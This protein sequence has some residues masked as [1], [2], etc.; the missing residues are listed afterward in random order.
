MSGPS[1]YPGGFA[2]GVVIKGIPLTVS[3]PGKVFWV[4]GTTVLA[5]GAVGGSNGNDG[6]YRRPFAT[7]DYA[8][9]KCTANRGDIIMVMPGHSETISSATSLVFDVAG[10][11]VIGLGTGSLRPDLNFSNTAGSVE[12]DAADV[13]LYNLT[14]TADV[15]AVVVGV[16][17]DAN[18]FTMDSCE[19]RYNAT[20]DDFITMIDIDAFDDA[21]ISN[22]VFHAEETAG[23]SE[24]IRMD[25][26]LRTKIINCH[27]TGDFTDGAIIGEGAV[28]TGILVADNY[29]YHSDTTGGEVID[30]NVASTGLI[31]GNRCGTLF[32][33]APYTAFDPGSC[34]CLE[35]YVANAID[36]SGALTPQT[37]SST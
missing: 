20:G 3:N 2:Q 30:L 6:S 18:G 28:S 25:D 36:E 10:V 11:A 34:L 9:G 24:A 17:V 12:V 31:V 37:V 22:C 29:I 27:F 19:F 14:L 8:V 33:T 16:N 21:V 13:T 15:T 7:I 1:N 4:N 5:P 35:N 32:P 23:C 26:A